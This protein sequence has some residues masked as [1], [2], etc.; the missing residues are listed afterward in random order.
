MRWGGGK[1]WCCEKK[2]GLLKGW[3]KG[4]CERGDG[5]RSD[6]ERWWEEE[7]KAGL[8]LR[9]EVKLGDRSS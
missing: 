5:K 8:Q 6:C 2:G 4:G 7:K 9:G 3:I 1:S